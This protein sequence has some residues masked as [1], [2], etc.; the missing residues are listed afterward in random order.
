MGLQ[1]DLWQKK[2]HG[3]L[4]SEV[5]EKQHSHCCVS[6]DKKIIP[7]KFKANIIFQS[8]QSRLPPPLLRR[9]PA[10]SHTSHLLPTSTKRKG[11]QIFSEPDCT[12]S[13]IT[14]A[15]ATG[16]EVR[17]RL[18]KTIS[19]DLPQ[20]KGALAPSS[21]GGKKHM[22]PAFQH[23]QNLPTVWVNNTRTA[24]FIFYLI[25]PACSVMHFKFVTIYPSQLPYSVRAGSISRGEIRETH[26]PVSLEATEEPKVD[27]I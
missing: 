22:W 17:P 2:Q 21:T 25:A 3:K 13:L 23:F 7:L 16:G 14:V 26:A 18:M 12:C 8:H 6:T 27:N 5:Q 4:H 20:N 1:R 19:A 11:K 9:T 10:D 24:A 15:M